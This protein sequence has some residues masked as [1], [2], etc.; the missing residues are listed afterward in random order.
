[1][2]Y[3]C[4]VPHVLFAKWSIQSKGMACCSNIGG[5]SAFPQHLLDRVARN[6]MNQQKD[7]A[8]YQPDD[9]KGV[10]DALE[11]GFQFGR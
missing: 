3:A 4:P 10:K 2:K 8:D 5:W 9:W 1:M 6:K 7:E 11:E